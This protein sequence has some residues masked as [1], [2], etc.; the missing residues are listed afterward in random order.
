MT[1]RRAQAS[2]SCLMGGDR[3]LELGT[4]MR[5]DVVSQGKQDA[6]Q[7]QQGVGPSGTPPQMGLLVN[8]ER[9]QEV[10][11]W[12]PIE[13]HCTEELDE[14]QVQDCYVVSDM[15]TK[16]AGTVEEGEATEK[17]LCQTVSTPQAQPP[18]QLSSHP[19]G[20]E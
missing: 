4:E 10:V 17:I 19:A 14:Q 6:Q 18:A 12:I 2:V 15:E 8:T 1:D 3:M 5:K 16:V 13:G 9:Q 11:E 20:D 7:K